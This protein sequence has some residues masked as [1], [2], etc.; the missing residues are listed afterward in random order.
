MFLKYFFINTLK[1]V[2]NDRCRLNWYIYFLCH[3]PSVWLLRKLIKLYYNSLNHTKSY[4]EVFIVAPP[5]LYFTEMNIIVPWLILVTKLRNITFPV[6]SCFMHSVHRIQNK[7]RQCYLILN[8]TDL[9]KCKQNIVK[10]NSIN[11]FH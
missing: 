5:T 3:I 1:N 7:C 8:I 9:I 6:C 4:T 2:L 10:H 11:F